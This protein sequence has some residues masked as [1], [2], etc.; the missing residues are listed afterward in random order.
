MEGYRR[1]LRG[2]V[3][4]G[5]QP[6]PEK[7]GKR[8]HMFTIKNLSAMGVWVEEWDD[9]TGKEIDERFGKKLLEELV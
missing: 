1:P 7:I 9:L 4:L 2:M 5:T 3:W 8:C 6:E